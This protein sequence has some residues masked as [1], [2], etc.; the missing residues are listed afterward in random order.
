MV[1]TSEY[2]NNAEL[3]AAICAICDRRNF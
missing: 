2:A 1:G 3:A